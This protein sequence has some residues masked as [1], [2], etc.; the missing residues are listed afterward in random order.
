MKAKSGAGI[1]TGCVL[2]LF[3][4]ASSLLPSVRVKGQEVWPH[5][6]IYVELSMALT[7]G[8]LEDFVFHKTWRRVAN[9]GYFHDR[10]MCSLKGN[11]S[12]SIFTCRETHRHV[13]TI[14]LFNTLPQLKIQK[15]CF[16][17][18]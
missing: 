1:K 15:F 5:D 4:F 2:W 12:K 10:F 17:K 6:R 8:G 7:V 9:A 3:F 14:F 13:F 16:Q 18:F 11:L